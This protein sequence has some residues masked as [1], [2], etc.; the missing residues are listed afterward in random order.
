MNIILSDNKVFDIQGYYQM[1][2][3]F[4]LRDD[5]NLLFKNKEFK[6]EL[7]KNNLKINN[8]LN[9]KTNNIPTSKYNSLLISK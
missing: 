2:N 4:E 7:I 9:K 3:N 8:L 1:I 6:I 5:D